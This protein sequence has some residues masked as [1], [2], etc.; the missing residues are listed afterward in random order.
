[1]I[2]TSRCVFLKQTAAATAVPAGLDFTSF[3]VESACPKINATD[4]S[5]FDIKSVLDH[6]VVVMK[7]GTRYQFPNL[8]M[9]QNP[10]WKTG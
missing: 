8:K 5:R 6:E 7:S 1:M 9:K 4:W 2:R 10:P 3:V